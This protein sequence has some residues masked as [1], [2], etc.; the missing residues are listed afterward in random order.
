MPGPVSDTAYREPSSWPETLAALTL[1]FLAGLN[2]IL[3][4]IPHDWAVPPWFPELGQALFLGLI[5]LPVAGVG[6]GWLRGFPPWSYPYAGSLLLTNLLLMRAATPGLHV[7]G[8]P[9]FGREL[10][11]WRVWIPTLVMAAGVLLLTRSLR[12]HGQFLVHFWQDWSLLSFLMVGFLPTLAAIG[13]DEVDRLFSLPFMMGLTLLMC[14]TALA[15]LRSGRQW[16]R[17]VA[18]VAGTGLTLAVIVAGPIAYWLPRDGV[19]VPAAVIMGLSLAA[20]I[21]APALL[22]LL[23]RRNRPLPGA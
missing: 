21:F 22:S 6:I 13:F 10:W 7:F 8:F 17:V 16:Q 18:L 2:L 19:H 15:Y 9:I 20:V 1:F 4:E 14:V 12:P 3:G 5:L 23:Q 11:G